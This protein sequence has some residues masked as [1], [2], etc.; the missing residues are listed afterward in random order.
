M[1]YAHN[2]WLDCAR[3]AG[4]I[5]LLFLLIITV[6]FICAL[7]KELKISEH[8]YY[9]TIIVVIGVSLLVYMNVEPIL[10]GCPLLFTV[11]VIILGMLRGNRCHSSHFI[12]QKLI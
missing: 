4:V 2:L 6:Y 9:R 1:G 3:V 10:E 5:P 7:W 11:F 12:T 8:D